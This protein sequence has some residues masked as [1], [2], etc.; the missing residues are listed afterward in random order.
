VNR[1]GEEKKILHKP[2]DEPRALGRP[3][4]SLATVSDN[5]F[6]NSKTL[7]G[8]PLNIWP[9]SLVT[10]CC[11]PSCRGCGSTV[12]LVHQICG[13]AVMS[14]VVKSVLSR[15]E[16]SRFAER[17]MCTLNIDSTRSVVVI[18]SDKTCLMRMIQKRK[19]FSDRIHENFQAKS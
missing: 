5:A 3:S 4:R 13:K 18:S 17:S 14:A 1:F 12:S 6:Q 16:T 15:K 7:T 10:S 19:G 2:R 8:R 11:L 9:T